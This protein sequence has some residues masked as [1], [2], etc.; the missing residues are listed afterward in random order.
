MSLGRQVR[1]LPP[2]F[3]KCTKKV[4]FF[5][6]FGPFFRRNSTHSWPFFYRILPFFCCF[7]KKSAYFTKIPRLSP[8]W[9]FLTPSPGFVQKCL[10]L[11]FPY[12]IYRFPCSDKRF[13]KYGLLT[14]FCHIWPYPAK[15]WDSLISSILAIPQ[16]SILCPNP[17]L[18]DQLLT[19]FCQTCRFYRFLGF[20]KYDHFLSTF[21]IFSITRF[22]WFLT[23]WSLTI[24]KFRP[25]RYVW[26]FDVRKKCQVVW[27]NLEPFEP[28][29]PIWT[30]L[31]SIDFNWN[32]GPFFDQNFTFFGEKTFENSRFDHLIWPP[33][34]NIG[35]HVKYLTLH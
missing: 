7:Y 24:S 3:W 27:W 26:S 32:Y 14:S 10:F 17:C 28:I 8:F 2:F 5:T 19:T 21:T 9:S 15:P 12:R 18:F 13:P 6:L 11:R 20:P 34:S 25:S 29:L 23:W 16:I 4:R 30:H 35:N 31:N 22:Y 33:F 1:F